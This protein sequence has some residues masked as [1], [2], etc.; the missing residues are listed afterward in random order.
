[1]ENAKRYQIQ[2]DNIPGEKTLSI[3][4]LFVD[5]DYYWVVDFNGSVSEVGTFHTAKTVRTLWIDGV[6]N[7]RDLGGWLTEDGNYRVKYNVAFRGAKFDTITDDGL[8]AVADLGLKTDVDLR[9][10]NEGVQAPLGGLA[11]WFLAGINGAAMYYTGD[12]SS[13]SNLTS[14]FVKATVN[15]IRV[16]KD[17]SKFPAYFHCSYG[18]DRTGTLGFLLLGLLGVSREDI[19]KDY[20]MTFLSEFGGGGGAASGQLVRINATIDWVQQNYA[21]GGTLQE[22]CEAYLRAA[23]LKADE[24]STIRANMLEPVFELPDVTG[25][26]V[27]TLPTKLTYIEGKEAF[28]PAGGEI[29]I[30]YS[31]GTSEDIAITADMV[32]GFDNKT[33]GPQTLTVTYSGFE[34]TFDIEITADSHFGDP[35]GDGAITVSDALI[36][37]RIAAKLAEETPEMLATCDVDGDGAVTVS[38]ALRILRVAAKLASF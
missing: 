28:D 24:I 38:D 4:N 1:M 10:Q 13:I 2:N 36:A 22:S 33:V 37:L 18:R 8:D 27:K 26:E 32:S 31:D 12:E 19:Q 11:E 29:T 17:P 21:V 34:A 7:T 16:Y 14:N 35:D 25:I 23:G 15:A 30:S 3:Q 9:T 20:E 6:S 5:T